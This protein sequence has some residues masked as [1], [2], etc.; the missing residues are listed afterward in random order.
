[1]FNRYPA[2]LLV[3]LLNILFAQNQCEPTQAFQNPLPEGFKTQGFEVQISKGPFLLAQNGRY[4]YLKIQSF[5][6]QYMIWDEVL[7]SIMKKVSSSE[8]LI[9]DF[10]NSQGEDM[11]LAY[12]LAGCF[13]DNKMPGHY[14]Y[15]SPGATGK[16][17]SLRPHPKVPTYSNPVVLLTNRRTC[18]AAEIATLVL[19]QLDQVTLMGTATAGSLEPGPDGRQHRSVTRVSMENRGI[20]VDIQLANQAVALPKALELLRGVFVPKSVVEERI[21]R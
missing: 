5:T 15:D 7:I 13:I 14:S 2:I 17:H 19:S 6:N 8:G 21:L 1:M 4:S 9:L 10:R 18:K 11:A 3:F 16:K 12:R 20:P